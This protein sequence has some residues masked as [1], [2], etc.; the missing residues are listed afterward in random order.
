MKPVPTRFHRSWGNAIGLLVLG[1]IPASVV[2]VNRDVQ[3]DGIRDDPDARVARSVSGRRNAAVSAPF[4]LL[5]PGDSGS[6]GRGAP[7]S[8]KPDVE[9][10][11][12]YARVLAP[13]QA[14]PDELPCLRTALA[15]ASPETKAMLESGLAWMYGGEY[16]KSRLAFQT[17]VRSHP[18]CEI[19]AP[20]YLA[21]GIS[22]FMEGGRENLLMAADQFMNYTVF[23]PSKEGMQELYQAAQV[24][25]ALAEVQLM[26]SAA[27]G[28][29]RRT[30]AEVAAKSLTAFLNE[31]PDHAQA[32]AAGAA[33]WQVKAL[34]AE[35]R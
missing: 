3:T 12:P 26:E 27:N 22:Y 21:C 4:Q 23:F 20:A 11:E 34:L 2:F 5:A 7:G 18:G 14:D 31:W 35:A 19:E 33:L 13:L 25:L 6:V 30:A 8:I 15:A 9:G 1:A 17:I 10:R 29:D 28:K 16:L 24:N 32:P